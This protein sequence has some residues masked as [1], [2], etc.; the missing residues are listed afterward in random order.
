MLY[1]VKTTQEHIKQMKSLLQEEQSDEFV[2]I[3]INNMYSIIDTNDNAV[4]M[5][6][7]TII[8]WKGRGQF[9]SFISKNCGK[10]LF[11]LIKLL[12]KLYKEYAPERLEVE[13]LYG[14]K[15]AIRLAE[16]FGFHKESLMFNYYHHKDYYLYVKFKEE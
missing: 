15:Q 12:K 4:Y 13:I 16:M 2:D 1:I 8:F 7:Q 10:K 5:I 3:D 6:F 11:A 14:F 9:K